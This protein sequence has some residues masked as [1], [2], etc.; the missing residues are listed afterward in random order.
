MISNNQSKTFE[1]K[2]H[3]SATN[4]F[5]GDVEGC[6]LVDLVQLACIEGYDRKLAVQR[7]KN[8]G[9]IYF[10]DSEIVHAESGKITGEEA[11]YDIMSW[12]SGTFS[13]VFSGTGTRT[14]DSSWNF[15]LIE[16]ARRIDEQ[17]EA[18]DQDSE[19]RKVLVV[20]DSRLFTKAFVKLFEEDI[21]ARV[22]G[23]ATNGKEALKFLE[24][25]VPDLV[26]L[27]I[28][29]PVMGGDLALKNIMIRSPAPVVLVSNYNEQSCSN[30]MDF[31][32]LGAVD[33]VAKPINPESWEIVSKRLQYILTNVKEF[34]VNNVSRAKS[35]VPLENR[36]V[37][38]K[39]ASRL[40][41]I[42]G[43]LGGILELQK[44]IPS[45]EYKNDTA[46]MV[47]QNMYPSITEHLATYLDTFTPYPTT[48]L[49]SGTE[50]LGGQ[51]RVGNCHGTWE[52][53]SNQGVPAIFGEQDE[54][55]NLSL[56]GDRLL[57]A[58]AE[59]FGSSLSV[60]ILSGTDMDLQHGLEYVSGKGG[61]IILQDPDSC[62]LPGPIHNL[63]RLAIESHSLKP[64][65]I[66]PFLSER[67]QEE[68]LAV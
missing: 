41:L 21:D 12:P 52:I 5:H 63:K 32:R 11:F 57:I 10:A 50:L 40:Q 27:D 39:P 49:I 66:G 19:Q 20:D 58:A 55:N 15:L 2:N 67:Q 42:L 7:G 54:H 25:Q 4:G 38:E 3:T 18:D 64:E 6:S 28:N 56:N 24:V 59:A 43:G 16:A 51:C 47:L 26:T 65:E 14:I 30:I 36:N 48:P 33:V 29:M 31:M 34:H 60:V 13:M 44:I 37:S 17:G 8:N 46:V 1:M 61:R 45:L 68:E 53:T 22:V 35:L 9:T 62:L 23:T